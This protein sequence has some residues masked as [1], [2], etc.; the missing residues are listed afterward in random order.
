MIFL[1]SKSPLRLFNIKLVTANAEFSSGAGTTSSEVFLLNEI[2]GI[3][4]YIFYL[5]II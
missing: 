2:P 3:S 4:F 1:K 5:I